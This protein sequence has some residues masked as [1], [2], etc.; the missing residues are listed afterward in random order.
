MPK[1][2]SVRFLMTNVG[3]GL[4][5]IPAAIWVSRKFG[6][7]MDHSPAVQRF[8]RELAGYNMTAASDFLATL[9]EF[10]HETRN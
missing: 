3:M 9:S 7:R 2:L 6:D 4:A 5:L 10:E 1:V 8:M